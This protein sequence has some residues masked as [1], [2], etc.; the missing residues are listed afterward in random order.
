MPRQT[1]KPLTDEQITGS[2]E[3][4]EGSD[5]PLPEIARRTGV[6]YHRIL[7]LAQRQG[8]A[9]QS[10]IAEI[11]RARRIVAQ[12]Y[13]RRALDYLCRQVPTGSRGRDEEILAE[14]R[15]ISLCINRRAAGIA[16][17]ALRE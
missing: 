12:G 5:L 17:L 2:R 6:H 9:R 7:S 1:L 11:T 4:Y 15:R 10:S 13:P 14:T 16:R 3:L 8:W